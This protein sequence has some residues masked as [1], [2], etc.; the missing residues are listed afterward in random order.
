VPHELLNRLGVDARVDQQGGEGVPA[1][2][3]RHGSKRLVKLAL[4]GVPF[5][6]LGP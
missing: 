5:V 4:L 3:K 2:V 1:L 6:G